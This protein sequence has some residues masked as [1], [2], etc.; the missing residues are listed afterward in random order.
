MILL[1]TIF[2]VSCLPAAYLFREY[3]FLLYLFGV[4]AIFPGVVTTFMG[5]GFAIFKTDEL[6][7][8]DYQLRHHSLQ[9]IQQQKGRIPIDATALIAIANPAA[10]QIE[11]GG[12]EQS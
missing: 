10:K 9:I 4:T 12:E 2:L 5:I 8:E 7:S 11:S 3:P 6:R 1:S